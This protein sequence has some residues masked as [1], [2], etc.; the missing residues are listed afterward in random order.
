MPAG[1]ASPPRPATG[2]PGS[3]EV[4][5]PHPLRFDPESED[6]FE[7][8]VG[9]PAGGARHPAGDIVEQGAD[10]PEDVDVEAVSVAVDPQLLLR[11]P[12]AHEQD[13]RAARVDVLEHALVVWGVGLEVAV[14]GADDVEIGVPAAQPAG[15]LARGPGLGAEQVERDAVASQIEARPQTQSAPVMRCGSSTPSARAATRTP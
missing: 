9:E 4:A 3:P 2:T 14:V 10:G 11:A 13:V 5:A 7:A 6:P 1:G 15:G 12:H 8:V